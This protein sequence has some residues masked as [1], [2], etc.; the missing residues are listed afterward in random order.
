MSC[1]CKGI[2]TR[3]MCFQRAKIRREGYKEKR[4]GGG[5]KEK[6]IRRAGDESRQEMV[7]RVKGKK[8]TRW[9][10]E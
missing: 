5:N 6:N 4:G 9:V 3:Q 10:E 1:G 2:I 7:G 8:E